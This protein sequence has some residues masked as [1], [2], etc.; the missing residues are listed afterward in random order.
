MPFHVVF[1]FPVCFIQG[2]PGIPG[3]PGPVGPKVRILALPQKLCRSF[4]ME[5][6]YIFLPVC[7]G[8]Y[9]IQVEWHLVRVGRGRGPLTLIV[10]CWNFYCSRT[11]NKTESS[12]SKVDFVI[13][14]LDFYK[15]LRSR[16]VL[17][18][19]NL[20]RPLRSLRWLMTLAFRA[21]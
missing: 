17:F 21:L 2:P 9:I 4:G 19:H 6:V 16:A 1:W 18:C 8:N 5:M 14:L 10:K 13:N 3:P 7:D 12:E 20:S 11:H 15:A